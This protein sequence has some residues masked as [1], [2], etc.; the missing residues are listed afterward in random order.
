MKLS[1]YARQQGISYRT[2][3]RWWQAGQIRGYQAPTGT[4]IVTEEPPEEAQVVTR[5][6]IY[7][8]VSSSERRENLERQVQRLEDYCASRG[9]QVAQ[10]VKEIACGVN[11]VQPK[12]LAILKDPGATRIVVEHKD[13]LNR[14]GFRYLE[15]LLTLQQRT[16]EVVNLEENDQEDLW[17][18]LAA[19]VYSFAVKLH[20]PRRAR[21]ETQAIVAQLQRGA[22]DAPGRVVSDPHE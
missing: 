10:V 11:D 3:L 16:I 17:E 22:A 15:T 13:R 21:R 9:Y 7:A 6:V 12:L 2:A 8:R 18:D 4:I 19:I 5:V 14:F 1:Q 20:G